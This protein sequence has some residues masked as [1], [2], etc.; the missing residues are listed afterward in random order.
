M[1]PQHCTA[2][3]CRDDEPPKLAHPRHPG[4]L[5]LRVVGGEVLFQHGPLVLGEAV[6]GREEVLGIVLIVHG[7]EPGREQARQQEGH[8]D[9]VPGVLA[10]RVPQLVEEPLQ[11]VVHQLATHLAQNKMPQKFEKYISISPPL[12]TRSLHVFVS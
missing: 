1:R 12:N 2:I 6:R 4:R 7:L 11:G 3:F 9:K 10:H 5:E 8:H